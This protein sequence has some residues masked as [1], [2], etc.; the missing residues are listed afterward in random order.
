MGKPF[1]VL[2]G[3]AKELYEELSASDIS[4]SLSHCNAYAVAYAVIE[5][6]R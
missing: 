1:V 4:L 2:T 6:G 3:K 5:V